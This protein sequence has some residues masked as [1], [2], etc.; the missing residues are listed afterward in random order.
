MPLYMSSP[1]KNPEFAPVAWQDR[2]ACLGAPLSIFFPEEIGVT[3][4]RQYDPAREFCNACEVR[5]QCLAYAMHHERGQWRRFGMFGGLPP[6][7]R[8]Q[9]E[10]RFPYRDWFENP[11]NI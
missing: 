5:T 10:Q 1:S 4:S 3:T 2:A 7:E 6:R 9:L 8:G 11:L